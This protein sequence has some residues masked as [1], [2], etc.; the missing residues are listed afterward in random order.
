MTEP[1]EDS[2]VQIKSIIEATGTANP[3]YITFEPLEK[4]Y[5]EWQKSA[6]NSIPLK[7]A[8]QAMKRGLDTF[9]SNLPS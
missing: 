7:T 6:D 3:A 1:I 9:N 5:V 4:Q 2:K 8:L